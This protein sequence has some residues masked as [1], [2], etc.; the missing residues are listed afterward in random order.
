[1]LENIR[2]ED[3]EIEYNSKNSFRF[4]GNGMTLLEERDEDTAFYI[5]K[6]VV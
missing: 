2:G 3:F 6:Q 4:M 1:M 5:A